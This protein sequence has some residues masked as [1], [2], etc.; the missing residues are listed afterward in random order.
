MST[1]P[2]APPVKTKVITIFNNKG[3]VGK[4]ITSWNLGEQIAQTGKSVLLIDFDPQ[5]NLSIAVLGETRFFSLLP[6]NTT[7]YGSCIRSYL[8]HFLQSTGKEEL[9]LHKGGTQSAPS[10]RIVAG[11]F[12][13][14]VYAESLTVG[15]DL[16]SGTGIT[17]FAILKR[18]IE[19]ANHEMGKPFDFVLLDLPPSFNSLVRAALYTSDYFLVPCTSDNFSAY[20]IGLIGQMLPAFMADWKQGMNRFKISNPSITE[21]DSIGQPKFAGWVFNGFDTRAGNVVRADQVHKDRLTQAIRDDLVAKLN[22][23]APTLGY[24]PIPSNLPGDF[25]VGTTEDMNVLVQNS[26]WQS[27]PVGR[28]DKV[29]QLMDLQNKR[30]W[31]PQQ[32]DQIKKIR[33]AYDKM[34]KNVIKVCI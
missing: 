28:L 5:C 33:G 7:S 32:L 29:Q 22:N 24:N 2:A 9:F 12:W 4:T 20:C 26:I 8:Q 25:C 18:I 27:V 21:F 6:Q 1:T 10:L 14:N 13:L 17:R 3:G 19:K 15:N 16:L 34:A 31:A 23:A 30:G 11:D